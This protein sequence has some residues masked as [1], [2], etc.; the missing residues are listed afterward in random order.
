VTG[1]AIADDWWPGTSDVDLVHV[2]SRAPTPA[3]LE[4]LTALHARSIAD[5]PIDGIY[6]TRAQ[7]EEGPDLL[8]SA[9][10]VVEGVLDPDATGGQISWVTWREI[11]S[12]W[13]AVAV[14]DGLGPWAWSS[15]RFPQARDGARAFSRANLSTYWDQLG[16]Q[17]R[18]SI[19][20]R[21]AAD[22]V[23]A[24]TIRWIALGPARLVATIETGEILSK[25]AA[26]GFASERWPRYRD[27][28]A[29]VVSS[30]RGGIDAF[31]VAD[32]ATSLDLLDD[33]VASSRTP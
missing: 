23:D 16:R 17:A 3:E 5:G 8:G 2:V 30:R 11:E 9:V 1:S 22:P 18:S 29:R 26:A 21:P 33:C 25:S 7:L 4:V 31:T 12:G 20:G 14:D 32:A 28:L 10:Q 24:R 6:L 19:T 27:L 13:E 15:S